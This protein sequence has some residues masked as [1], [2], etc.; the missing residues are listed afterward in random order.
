MSGAGEPESAPSG[1]SL[2]VASLPA[3]VKS[4]LAKAL[5]PGGPSLVRSPDRFL[6]REKLAATLA[7]FA[8]VLLAALWLAGFADACGPIQS[9]VWACGYA[10]ALFPCAYLAVRL[11][12]G[13]LDARTMPFAP[14]VYVTSEDVVVA[15]GPTIRV[16]PISAIAGVGA[17]R[18][19]PLSPRAELTL[20]MESE[21]AETLSIPA[22]EADAAVGALDR[23]REAAASRPAEPSARAERRRDPL[24]ELKRS[25]AWERARAERPASGLLR[26]ILL[27]IPVALALG[28]AALV[29]R[30]I[31]SDGSALG[32]ATAT[33][34]VEALRCYAENGYRRDAVRRVTLPHAAYLVAL[35]SGDLQRL[36]AYVE[37]YPEGPDTAQ[38]RTAWLD[39]EYAAARDDAWRLRAFLARFPEA[40]QATEARARLPRLALDAAIAADDVGSYA[41]VMREHPGTAEAA[42]ASRRRAARYETVLESLVP[43]G[44]RPE[45][46]RFF[47][48]L[49]AYLEGHETH[50][51]LVR[52]RTPSN[53]ELRGFDRIASEVAGRP[54]EPIAPSFSR[55]LSEQREALVFDRLRTAFAA[56]APSDVLPIVRGRQLPSR[57]TPE[58]REALLA[59]VP[60]EERA[61]RA[62]EL[63]RA[64]EDES[65]EPELRIAY[66][67][68]PDGRVYTADAPAAPSFEGDPALREAL[69]RLG[70]DAAGSRGSL[71]DRPVVDD[72]AFVGFRVRFEID[73][74]TPGSPERARFD[75]EV[76]PPPSFVVQG[77]EDLA[78]DRTIYEAMVTEAFDRLGVE[79]ERALFG[80]GE[81]PTPSD[82]AA[83]VPVPSGR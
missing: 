35:E 7:P 76:A 75:V 78:S 21:P 27:A 20:W 24:S 79:L 13:A 6:A 48:A 36:G 5:G 46:V 30:N 32:A 2:A 11:A 73:M 49:F 71:L 42:E 34:D 22:I 80:T 16:V 55:R 50:D 38:A 37:A 70:L 66:E 4:D 33:N 69:A 25:Q 17:P 52:F 83:R 41:H 9:W 28:A 8:L 81:P 12:L 54:V 57:S 68:V 1:R 74:R 15:H 60:E 29:V 82:T 58:A 65:G 26:A 53:E 45:A 3:G 51:V 14:G 67:V 63:A 56:V 31:A 72:R 59:E 23:A 77:G 19:L 62:E 10:A 47:R 61:A 18:R 44:G 64:E 39:G 40:P 43:R